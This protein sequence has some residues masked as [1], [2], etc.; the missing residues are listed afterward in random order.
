MIDR[1]SKAALLTSTAA[2]I[3]E[4]LPQ[5][6]PPFN[7]VIGLRTKG[8]RCAGCSSRPS[9]SKRRMTLEAATPTRAMIEMAGRA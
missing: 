1:I 7:S 3:Q 4:V 5:P 2:A 8:A 6:E 9:P